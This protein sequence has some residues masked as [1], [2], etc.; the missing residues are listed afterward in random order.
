TAVVECCTAVDD[1]E[2][3]VGAAIVLPEGEPLAD[4]LFGE[5]PSR[6][7]LTA[8]HED[9]AEIERR[10]IAASVPMRVMGA[11]GGKRLKILTGAP[12]AIAN[13][14]LFALRDARERC[15]EPIIGM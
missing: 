12:H 13:L 1:P 9:L 8:R 5:A 4:A 11:T 10:A 3:M 7:L 14:D 6:V 2:G 15:L